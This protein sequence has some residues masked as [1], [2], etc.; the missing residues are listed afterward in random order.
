MSPERPASPFFGGCRRLGSDSATDCSKHRPATYFFAECLNQH[1]PEDLIQ[2][3]QSECQWPGCPLCFAPVPLLYHF[4]D[5]GFP[6]VSRAA[7]DV[8]KLLNLTCGDVAI[9]L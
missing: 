6:Q 5:N 3:F 2:P 4:A 7:T 9:G 1:A 8:P